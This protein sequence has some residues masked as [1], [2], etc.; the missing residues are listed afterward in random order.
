M[1]N[2]RILLPIV[3]LL[4]FHFLI[5]AHQ[6]TRQV[7]HIDEGFHV[8]RAIVVWDFD[9]NPG[10]F[11]HGKLLLYYW[12][13][14]FDLQPVSALH[15]SRTA[16]AI[17]SLLLAALIYRL[18]L[19]L[20]NPTVGLAAMA[21]YSIFP[22]SVFFER[23]AMADAFAATFGSVVAWRSLVFARRPSWREGGT[24]GAFITLATMAKLTMGP[25]ALLPV[26][27]AL[28][29]YDWQ[30]SN[31]RQQI[32]P[33]I[34]TYVPPLVLAASMLIVAW[35]PIILPA[36]Y[37]HFVVSD[38]YKLLSENNL[39]QLDSTSPLTAFLDFVLPQIVFLTSEVVLIVWAIAAIGLLVWPK[40]RRHA[41]FL[42]GWVMLITLFSLTFANQPR[43]R[44]YVPTLT[45]MVLLIVMGLWHLWQIQVSS[46]HLRAATRGA[47]A[48][49]VAA[50]IAVFAAPFAYFAA[51][52]PLELRLSSREEDL[53]LTGTQSG[54]AIEQAVALLESID[55][56]PEHIYSNWGTCQIF[57][58]YTDAF[59][60]GCLALADQPEE[61]TRYP[62]AFIVRNGDEGGEPSRYGLQWTRLGRF[63]RDGVPFTVE[64]WRIENPDAAQTLT[65]ESHME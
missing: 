3:I 14:L 46:P 22:Y 36:L 35:L 65:T 37:S 18:G 49:G 40:T 59:S 13:G 51:T 19:K 15:V 62:V 11:M 12:L 26:L 34:K 1:S 4:L 20:A 38:P 43:P 58:F 17:F 47:I 10:Q 60:V 16:I 2:K 25:V 31:W 45:P 63:E 6:I 21:L 30:P 64:V 48:I 28:A 52:D 55:P 33:W 41:I 32:R 44:Y 7:P 23:L 57:Y 8:S 39:Q 5:R 56:M 29:Y 54:P 42:V 9:R 27:A 53:Y 61:I 50:W 24:L